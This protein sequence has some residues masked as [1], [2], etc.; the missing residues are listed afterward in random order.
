VAAAGG[1]GGKSPP[2]A[3]EE[4]YLAAAYPV[5][6]KYCE[7]PPRRR[8]VAHL[9]TGVVD[10]IGHLNRQRDVDASFTLFTGEPSSLRKATAQLAD[11]LDHNRCDPA[12]AR[13]LRASLRGNS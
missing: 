7:P 6:M 9:A 3:E 11:M 8:A 2:S 5:V 12:L 10:R 4:A 13:R 1:C